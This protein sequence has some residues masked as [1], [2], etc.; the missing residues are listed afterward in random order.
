M[1]ETITM[2]KFAQKNKVGFTLI[3]LIVVIAIL[4]IIAALSIPAFSGLQGS[5]E[6]RVCISNRQMVKRE[7]IVAEQSF[8]RALTDEEADN[9]LNQ[10]DELCPA[11]GHITL[12]YVAYGQY[13]ISC[14]LHTDEVST[15]SSAELIRY[16]F[17]KIDLS[18]YHS[19]VNDKAFNDYYAAYGWETV[20]LDG[21]SYLAK[22]YYYADANE[23]IIFANTSNNT[24]KNWT[25]NLIYHDG[26]WYRYTNQFGSTNAS[27]SVA[28]H[29]WDTLKAEV[30][31]S[32]AS[33]TPVTLD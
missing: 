9:I 30:E 13:A 29:T 18:A 6:Q 27:V 20:T 32:G 10:H 23:L 25:A 2:Q 7:L 17:S 14:D 21:K 5:A 31:S 4:G 8:S 1:G 19:S 16:R 15:V 11:G 26:I 22:P 24:N 28:N 12:E 3:E 33:L